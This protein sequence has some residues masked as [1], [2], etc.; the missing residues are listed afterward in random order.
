MEYI[1]EIRALLASPKDIII[2]SHRNPDGDAIGASLALYH[3]LIQ[4]GHQVQILFPSDYPDFFDWMPAV[5]RILDFDNS[6]EECK[7]IAAKAQIVFYLDFN[8]I[9]RIDK[10]GEYLETLNMR[11]IMID[12]H[13]FPEP[14]ADYIIS[15]TTASSTCE[16]IYDF[17]CNMGDKLAINRTVGD[18]IYT[19]IVTDTGSFKYNTSPKLFRLVSE[20]VE[21]GVDDYELQDLITNNLS[22]K[23]LRLLGHCL[24]NRM[25]IL[26]EYKTGII[27]LTKED[28]ATFDIQRGDTEGIVNY[29]LK[30]REIRFAAF[31]M[32]Q[33]TI[34]KM[35]F[36]SKGDFSV[37]ELARKNFKG[38]GHKNAAGGS[39]FQTLSATLKRFKALLPEYKS[40]LN[41]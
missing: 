24:H 23:Q 7:A 17:I 27:A 9:D 40:E 25:E 3:Y 37:H 28:Y 4:S 31:I 20:L 21:L 22:E 19:G 14:A 35:S 30:L 26:P 6:P 41:H 36:R 39:S 34:V 12:H 13:L 2:T 5:Q 32:E 16:M 1:S 15:D 33:P 11:R 18:C 38:G 10:L 8:S 29:L